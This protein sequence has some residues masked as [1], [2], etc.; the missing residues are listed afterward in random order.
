MSSQSSLNAAADAAR[1]FVRGVLERG[2]HRVEAQVSSGEGMPLLCAVEAAF[3]E[4]LPRQAAQELVWL[5]AAPPAGVHR[6]R[7]AAFGPGHELLAEAEHEFG[8]ALTAA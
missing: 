4:L 5:S 8:E 7:L 1:G 3:A 2:P 6:L